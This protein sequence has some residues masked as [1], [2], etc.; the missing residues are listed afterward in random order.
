MF[1]DEIIL[2]AMS[3]HPNIK[4]NFWNNNDISVP[5]LYCHNAYKSSKFVVLSEQKKFRVLFI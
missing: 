3:P 5:S 4:C 2:N 1:L